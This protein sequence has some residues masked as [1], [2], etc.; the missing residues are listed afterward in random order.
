MVFS[1]FIWFII[2]DGYPGYTIFR[3]FNSTV[4]V[5]II[6]IIETVVELDFHGSDIAGVDGGVESDGC[7]YVWCGVEFCF[8]F[9]A[10]SV[11][12]VAEYPVGMCRNPSIWW[13]GRCAEVLV[14]ESYGCVGLYLCDYCGSSE[15][16]FNVLSKVVDGGVYRQDGCI[17]AKGMVNRDAA[18]IMGVILERVGGCCQWILL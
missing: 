17:T 11:A 18:D 10:T 3:D 2:P 7:F 14:F 6:F 1:G 9:G 8:A 16:G 13:E 15:V 12:G 4:V 5:I